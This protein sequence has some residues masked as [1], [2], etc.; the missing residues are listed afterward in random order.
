MIDGYTNQYTMPAQKVS[1]SR[2]TKEWRKKCV[3]AVIGRSHSN[4]FLNG[5]SRAERM[6][7]NYDLYNGVYDW[8]DLKHVTN[9]FNVADGFPAKPQDI[10]IIRGKIEVLRGEESKRPRNIRVIHSNQDVVSQLQEVK[11]NMVLNTVAVQ[12]MQKLGIETESVNDPDIMSFPQ[13][14]QYIS[15]EYQD[16]ME[17][18]AYHLLNYLY[19]KL[20]LDHEFLNMW[21][22]ALIAGEEICYVGVQ[23]GE[24]VLERVNPIFFEH[25]MSPDL[26]FIEDG[27]WA[28]RSMWMTPQE[29]Y[30]RFYDKLTPGDLDELLELN[31]TISD[32]TAAQPGE[33]ITYRS[34]GHHEWL[35]D[36]N[37]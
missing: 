9:P 19:N 1:L 17:I 8:K 22:D 18:T 6:K 32:G 36:Y 12:L 2:K 29:M 35:G 21:M 25:D 14:E 16:V 37:V 10:N 3:D 23:N 13:I 11:K 4:T 7:S 5:V 24:P 26:E 30:D 33:Y 20:G 31:N 28:V 27:D 15:S 34:V